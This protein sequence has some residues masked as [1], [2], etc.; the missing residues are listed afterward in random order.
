MLK[1]TQI[2]FKGFRS[3]MKNAYLIIEERNLI[4]LCGRNNLEMFM[5]EEK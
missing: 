1:I 2:N 4:A 5:E 3:I